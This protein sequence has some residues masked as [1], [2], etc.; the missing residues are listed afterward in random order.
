M[1]QDNTPTPARLAIVAPCAMVHR[2]SQA[3]ARRLVKG[4]SI[5]TRR[6]YSR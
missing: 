4:T 3:A 2:S 5:G 6:R 1:S